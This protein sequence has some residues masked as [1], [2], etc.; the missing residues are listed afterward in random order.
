VA[1]EG[2]LRSFVDQKMGGQESSIQRSLFQTQ[3]K[4]LVGRPRYRWKILTSSFIKFDVAG[5]IDLVQ[6]AC[7]PRMN[8]HSLCHVGSLCTCATSCFA[9]RHCCGLDNQGITH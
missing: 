5:E 9:R 8:V 4:R 3:C 1:C 6:G 7:K 2:V